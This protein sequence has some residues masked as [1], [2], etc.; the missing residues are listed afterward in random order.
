MPE[1]YFIIYGLLIELIGDFFVTVF[2]KRYIRNNRLVPT[3]NITLREEP[4]SFIFGESF[5]LVVV[6]ITLNLFFKS[7]V[8]V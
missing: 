5:V 2:T 6:L 3:D 8:D 7:I 1:T 4:V